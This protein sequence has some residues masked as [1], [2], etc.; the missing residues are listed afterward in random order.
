MNFQPKSMLRRNRGD[1]AAD[2][3]TLNSRLATIDNI[4][5]HALIMML[6]LGPKRSQFEQIRTEFANNDRRRDSPHFQIVVNLNGLFALLERSGL[7][8]ELKSSRQKVG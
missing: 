3:S 6:L 5:A 4:T 1:S 7:L 8:A 2:A